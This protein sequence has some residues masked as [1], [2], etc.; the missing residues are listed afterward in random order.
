[1]SFKPKQRVK[2]TTRKDA[3]T[4]VVERVISSL[5]GDWYEVKADGTA[6]LYRLRAAHITAI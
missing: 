4:G 1:M 3:G 2:F 6:K 5:R